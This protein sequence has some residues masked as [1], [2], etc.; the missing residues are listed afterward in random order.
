MDGGLTHLTLVADSSWPSWDART[1]MSDDRKVPQG[2]LSRF[3]MLASVGARTGMSLLSK[4]GANAAAERTAEVLGRMRGLAAKVGQIASYVDG[5][6]PEA[7][8]EV[9][10]AAL[11]KLRDHAMTSSFSEVQ[12]TIEE[13]F[14]QPLDKLFSNFDKTPFAS[15]SI[16]QVHRAELADGRAVAVKVQHPGVADAVE[17]DLANAGVLEPLASLA[18]GRKVDSKLVFEEMKSRLREE[19]DYTLEATRQSQFRAIHSD[20]PTIRIPEVIAD[21]SSRRVLTSELVAGKTLAEVSQLSE[22][23]RRAFAETMWR[24]VFK[25]NLIGGMFNA[26][27]H[28]GNYIF[29]ERG[30]VHFIDFG[31]VEPIVGERRENARGLHLAALRKDEAEFAFFSK[32]LLATQGGQWEELAVTYSRY[33][34]E[35]IFGS[36]YRI[37]R[38]YAADLVARLKEMGKIA[39]KLPKGEN[40]PVPKGMIFMNRL[41]FGFY[42]V[43]A[44]LDV[45]VDYAAVERQFLQSGGL[46]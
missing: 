6:I 12:R 40:V 46:L 32:R 10:E 13:D 31:C 24:F 5:V 7:N 37:T 41:Q 20:D 1:R 30:Q 21:R 23:E 39:R 4:G 42:S 19:L 25:G 3:A 11:G 38:S 35:P 26:D 18:G 15:A 27:P 8:R 44:R 17:N 2:K 34:F 36:P 16:G 29:G 43:L 22:E 28:P 45:E 33:C 14:G 9:Y